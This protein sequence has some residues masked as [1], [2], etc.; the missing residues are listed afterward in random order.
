MNLSFYPYGLPLGMK[1]TEY[2][3]FCF[4]YTSGKEITATY[5][6]NVACSCYAMN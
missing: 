5:E 1:Q 4:N 6:G 2:T 3:S